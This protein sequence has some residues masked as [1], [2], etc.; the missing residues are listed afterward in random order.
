MILF[1]EHHG[2]SASPYVIG[3]NF[4]R[5]AWYYHRGAAR[6]STFHLH[7]NHK[8][9]K[10]VTPIPGN[11]K[12]FST[13]HSRTDAAQLHTATTVQLQRRIEIMAARPWLRAGLLLPLVGGC[14][15]YY[16]RL[17]TVASRSAVSTRF[18]TVGRHQQHHA[19]ARPHI[20]LAVLSVHRIALHLQRVAQR[21]SRQMLHSSASSGSSPSHAGSA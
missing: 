12:R 11:N 19:G 20:T 3:T 1:L 5:N 4:P 2:T 9:S 16:V 21:P 7:C 17:H 14:R 15:A 18:T 6:S 8:Y 13:A 10:Q